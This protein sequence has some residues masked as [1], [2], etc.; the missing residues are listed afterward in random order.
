MSQ[1]DLDKSQPP[2]LAEVLAVD[3]A[4]PEA[5]SA[6]ELG[7]ILRHQLATP[8]ARDTNSPVD[9]PDD[10]GD[11][12]TYGQLLAAGRPP[13]DVLRR[14]KTFAKSSKADPN[15]PL[16]PE[17]ATVLYFAT[18]CRARLS[19]GSR[20]SGLDDAGV[21]EG[22]RWTLRQAWVPESIHELVA[23]AQQ[24]DRGDDP[25]PGPR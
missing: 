20:I 16:P 7:A 11:E 12:L 17:V 19:H 18:I 4:A 8:I 1:D 3:P 13:L 24:E 6:E 15:G 5:L 9:S 21:A 10:G 25:K 22:V 23:A 2:R 14:V